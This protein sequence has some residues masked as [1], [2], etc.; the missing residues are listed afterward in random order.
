MSVTHVPARPRLAAFVGG[1]EVRHAAHRRHRRGP[2]HVTD[3]AD[4][5]A[6]QRIAVADDVRSRAREHRN[7]YR[8]PARRSRR[9]ASRGAASLY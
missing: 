8:E 2:D 5:H 3:D 1:R 6:V 4:I 9:A 7:T